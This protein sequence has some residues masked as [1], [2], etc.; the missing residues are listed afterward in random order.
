M[1]HGTTILCNL[2]RGNYT[3][4][5]TYSNGAQDVST[6][7]IQTERITVGDLTAVNS[8]QLN[9][10]AELNPDVYTRLNDLILPQSVPR[11]LHGYI[12]KDFSS[13][14]DYNSKL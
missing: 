3:T 7:I 14:E 11:L 4:K 2:H 8:I 5:T 6:D 10:A 12:H 1:I 9:E 13:P